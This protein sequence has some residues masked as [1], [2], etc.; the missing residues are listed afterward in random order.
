MLCG[1]VCVCG[2]TVIATNE[3]VAIFGFEL[4]IYVLFRL[5][6]RNVHEAVE[7]CKDACAAAWQAQRVPMVWRGTV[8]R[9]L[10]SPR[11]S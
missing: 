11:Q 7:A 6:H 4:S 1:T 3:G 10:G 2:R 9:H 8:A 5:F